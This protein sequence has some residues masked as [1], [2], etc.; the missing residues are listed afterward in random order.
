MMQ[1]VLTILV[2]SAALFYLG[3]EAYLKLIKKD[4]SCDG[5]AF[6]PESS[7]KTKDRIVQ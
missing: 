3:R 4:A 2:V 7:R 5:C 6:N 1:T